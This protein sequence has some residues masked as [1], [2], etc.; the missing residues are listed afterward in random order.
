MSNREES[1][2]TFDQASR[3]LP[4]V[5]AAGC[6]GGLLLGVIFGNIPFGVAGGRVLAPVAWLIVAGKRS[7][8]RVPDP[9]ADA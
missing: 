3:K 7:T 8:T 4:G 5:I 2:A 9:D 1:R 6:L